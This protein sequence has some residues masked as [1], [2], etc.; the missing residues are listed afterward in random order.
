MFSTFKLF[1]T[2]LPN[3]T[4][5]LTK[6]FNNLPDCL[7]ISPTQGGTCDAYNV[8]VHY[9]DLCRNLEFNPLLPLYTTEDPPRLLR[10]WYPW[11]FPE[12]DGPRHTEIWWGEEK[13]YTTDTNPYA[14]FDRVDATV[15]IP[16]HAE[17]PGMVGVTQPPTK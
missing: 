8:Q 17:M 12:G 4:M 9:A 15:R 11:E 2:D 6:G 10:V 14:W 16:L 5:T 1:N 13:D 7:C 3:K